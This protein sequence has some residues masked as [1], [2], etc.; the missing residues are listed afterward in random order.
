MRG[1]DVLRRHRVEFN[2]LTVVNRENG[3]HPVEVY[4]FLKSIGSRFMQFI[5]N[6]MFTGEGKPTLQSVAPKQFGSFLSRLFDRW[7]ENDVGRIFVQH[8]DVTLGLVMGGPASL[9]VHAETCGQALAL[10]HNGDLYSC[11]HFVNAGNKLGNIGEVGLAEMAESQQQ[12]IFG[13][14]KRDALPGR[15]GICSYLSLCRGGCPAQRIPGR[16]GQ[17][18]R[19]YLCAGYRYFYTHSLPDR[20]SVV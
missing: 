19:N 10:E 13:R 20:K 11:D 16:G 14:N 18:D 4:D 9:C 15:C 3:S 17:A 7:I 2:T 6:V 8:F 12:A 5:P 1:L